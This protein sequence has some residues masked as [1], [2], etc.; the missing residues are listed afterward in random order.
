MQYYKYFGYLVS[1]K[2]VFSIF[3]G[4]ALN[5]K[6]LK[7][8]AWKLLNITHLGGVIQLGLKSGLLEDGWFLS[9]KTKRSVNKN[10]NP[11]AWYTYPFL[12][13]IESR[14]SNTFSVFE[15]G[16]GNSTLWY[17]L[18][19]KSIKAVEHDKVWFELVK[20][21][22]PSNAEVVFKELTNKGEYSREVLNSKIL[23]DLII[24]DG[25]DRNNCA[26][27]AIK[28]LSQQGILIFDNT[29]REEYLE[30]ISTIINLGF[31]KIDFWGLSPITSHNT[32]TSVL[33]RT[34]NCLNI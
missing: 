1:L 20:K 32:C 7:R 10:G 2:L 25:V 12:K 11:I 8:I 26:L 34:E 33:Y 27:N 23:Y 17:A 30:S 21:K 6:L 14:L 3:V 16:C 15:F 19:V 18:K 31:K 5:M 4:S 28:Q 13:F 24:I 29:D 22:L 9:F